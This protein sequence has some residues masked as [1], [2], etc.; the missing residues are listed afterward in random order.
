MYN[1]QRPAL[2]T[3]PGTSPGRQRIAVGLAALGALFLLVRATTTLLAGASFDAP[4][5]GWRSLWQL[6]IVAMLG[7]GIV[8]R[9]WLGAALALVAV[10]YAAAT[11][12][13]VAQPDALIGLIPVDMRDRIVHPLVALIAASAWWLARGGRRAV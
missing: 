2:S 8:R 10:I 5:D 13:E 9:T 1:A 11:L 7:A 3:R 12:S 6:L 4:G